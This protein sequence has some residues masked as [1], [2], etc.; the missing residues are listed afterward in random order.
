MRI[1]Q[2]K[3]IIDLKETLSITKTANNFF[4]SHQALSQTINTLEKEL[5]VV[6]FNRSNQGIVF[7]EVGEIIY[8]Y[9]KEIVGKHENLLIQ[10]SPYKTTEK[11]NSL[12]GRLSI[13]AIPRYF[14]PAFWDFISAYQNNN[15]EVDITI[16]SCNAEKAIKS[17]KGDPSSISLVTFNTAKEQTFYD[18]LHKFRLNCSLKKREVLSVC[19]NKKSKLASYKSLDNNDLKQFELTAFDYFDELFEEEK[20]NLKIK[21]YVDNYDQQKKLLMNPNIYTVCSH[22]EYK[23]F[24]EKNHV[25][26]PLKENISNNYV[27]LYC[28]NPSLQVKDFL[29]K[30]LNKV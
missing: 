10:I 8:E 30:F 17:V 20:L 19:V 18:L 14:T 5:G 25:Y 2:L 6:L 22:E 4:I 29:N 12:T 24:G 1:E 9:A 15:P 3:Y 26:I 27:C 23:I 21:Y 16:K 13:Y 28:S 11:N 7:T